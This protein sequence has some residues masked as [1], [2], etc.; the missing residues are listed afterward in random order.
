LT[1]QHN[2][3]LQARDGIIHRTEYQAG[4]GMFDID[5]DGFIRKAEF[6]GACAPRFSFDV[7]DA[8]GDGRITVE[9]YVKGF[10]MIDENRDGVITGWQCHCVRRTEC[11]NAQCFHNNG[12]D[13]VGTC[14]DP[15][16]CPTGDYSS[17]GRNEEGDNACR[18][19]D[20]GK[21]A[22]IAGLSSCV[23]A[24]VCHNVCERL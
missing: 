10:D 21:Y 6:E 11:V 20:S 4:F 23:C 5:Q 22:S 15:L 19:C 12:Y 13:S 18:P 7:L 9:E 2:E 3:F 1:G 24:C 17:T 8:D 16:P 14:N